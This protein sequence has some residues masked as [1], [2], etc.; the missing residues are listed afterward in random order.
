MTVTVKEDAL[1]QSVAGWLPQAVGRFSLCPTRA[2]R[3]GSSHAIFRPRPASM[4]TH[5]NTGRG[6]KCGR[7]PNNR[8]CCSSCQDCCC[9]GWRNGRCQCC[10]STTRPATHGHLLTCPC[11]RRQSAPEVK[12]LQPLATLMPVSNS[13]ASH[14]ADCPLR[15]SSRRHVRI[16]V[17]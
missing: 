11:T 2:R 14:L 3:P 5:G 9:C 6:E 16:G 1:R 8:H 13:C 7:P 17:G 12:L 4:R 15:W 10:C